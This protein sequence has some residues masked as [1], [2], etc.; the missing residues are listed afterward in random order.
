VQAVRLA[1]LDEVE[2]A[3]RNA[4]DRVA[5]DPEHGK[6]PD[7]EWTK[8]LKNA[9][10]TLGQGFGF[11]VYASTAELANQGK[12]LFDLTWTDEPA[13]FLRRVPASSIVGDRYLLGGWINEEDKFEWSL[14]AVEDE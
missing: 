8:R 10:A 1:S 13:G 5:R 9:L 7:A 4:V 11:R 6:W 12:W 14:F 3:I 2:V